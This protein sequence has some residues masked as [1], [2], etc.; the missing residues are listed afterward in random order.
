MSMQRTIKRAQERTLDAVELLLLAEHEPKTNNTRLA[1]AGNTGSGLRRRARRAIETAR[2]RFKPEQVVKTI[3]HK[4]G[5]A[6]TIVSF[7][8]FKAPSVANIA[9]YAAQRMKDMRGGKSTA[10]V[11]P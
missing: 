6:Q 2:A 9:L 4:D 3:Q 8:Q 11:K 1:L 5:S 10:E 7:S